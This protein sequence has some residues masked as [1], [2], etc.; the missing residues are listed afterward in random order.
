MLK[1]NN[2]E[3]YLNKIFPVKNVKLLKNVM[4]GLF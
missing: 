1:K 2:G 3:E 4:T